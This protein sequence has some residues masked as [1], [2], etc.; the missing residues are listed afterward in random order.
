MNEA[1]SSKKEDDSPD[2]AVAGTGSSGPSAGIWADFVGEKVVIDTPTPYIYLGTL[3]RHEHDALVLEDV[4]VH[5]SE[6]SKSTKEVYI[7][8]AAD[9]GIR[10]NRKKVMVPEHRVL[11]ISRL[12]DTVVY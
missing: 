4:D 7:M 2:E 6:E 9:Q 5:D 10:V 1:S 11:S 12:E 8:K 3:V